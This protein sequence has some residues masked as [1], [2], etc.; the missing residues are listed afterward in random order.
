VAQLLHRSPVRR[1]HL[2][3]AAGPPGQRVADQ[4]VLRRRGRGHVAV[5]QPGRPELRE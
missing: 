1:D 3:D 2:Q 4:S 5:L